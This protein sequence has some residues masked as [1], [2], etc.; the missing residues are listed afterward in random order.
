MKQPQR[1]EI[2]VWRNLAWRE[3]GATTDGLYRSVERDS[4]GAWSI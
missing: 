2:I 1:A 3:N 4:E